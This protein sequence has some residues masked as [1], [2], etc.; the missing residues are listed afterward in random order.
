LEILHEVKILL[1]VEKGTENYTLVS[2][3][4]DEM[5]PFDENARVLLYKT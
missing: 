5:S 1:V 3:E 2:K 4:A